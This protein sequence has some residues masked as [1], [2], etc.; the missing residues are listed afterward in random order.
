MK[1]KDMREMS[2]EELENQRV[3]AVKELFSLRMQQATSQVEK[4]SRIRELRR[5]IARI[6]T[7]QN[8]RK[9]IST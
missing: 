6:R 1:P 7:I 9:R 4:P 8:E 3:Q 2:P 5:D